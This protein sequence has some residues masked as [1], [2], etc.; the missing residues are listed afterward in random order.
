MPSPCKVEA[1][2]EVV[3]YDDSPLG[4]YFE[5]IEETGDPALP[6][7]ARVQAVED[8]VYTQPCMRTKFWDFW[9]LIWKSA[10]AFPFRLDV[11]SDPR[12][13]FHS[14]FKER[15]YAF[16]LDQLSSSEQGGPRIERRSRERIWKS[17]A[18]LGLTAGVASWMVV[19]WMFLN[20]LAKNLPLKVKWSVHGLF[21]IALSPLIGKT[22]NECQSMS[23]RRRTLIILDTYL[24]SVRT[25]DS[26]ARKGIRTIQEVELV[27]RGYRLSTALSPISFVERSSGAKRC[28]A[29]RHAVHKAI[30]C[31]ITELAMG[32][33]ALNNIILTETENPADLPPAQS[34]PADVDDHCIAALKDAL[35][36]TNQLN[37]DVL[38]TLL[39]VVP[40]A[41]TSDW[42]G[43]LNVV[44]SVLEALVATMDMGCEWMKEASDLESNLKVGEDKQS[45]VPH[46][47]TRATSKALDSLNFLN[48]R[49][50]E[51][52]TK[53]LISAQDVQAECDP[54]GILQQF[55]ALLTD[56][57][58]LSTS[59]KHTRDL[60]AD[61]TTPSFTADLSMPVFIDAEQLES[62]DV[63]ADVEPLAIHD[64]VESNPEELEGSEV[65][66][67]GYHEEV[68]RAKISREE[69]IR[70]Q[71]LKREAESRTKADRLVQET[72]MFELKNVL[73]LRKGDV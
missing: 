27:A 5:S 51:V 37:V 49:L 28:A 26:T 8:A 69:R 65:I 64:S 29:L 31:A 62:G 56:I 23:F 32:G 40:A 35:L 19:G 71:K 44:R 36:I 70:V 6:A 61:L 16:L 15:I 24:Q 58:A 73:Q 63:G 34:A 17:P 10:R 46:G 9:S 43:R 42:Y 60:L 72:L 50:Q 13:G 48:H 11:N 7:E 41:S 66:Y 54:T 52:R 25:F 12:S 18:V 68:V 59:W 39:V 47:K 3:I 22:A 21:L 1:V 38:S 2:E 20:P 30:K 14:A 45:S 67:E 4:A 33:L 57:T 55:D 53:V